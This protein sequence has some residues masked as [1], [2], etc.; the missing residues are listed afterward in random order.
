MPRILPDIIT[1]KQHQDQISQ[2]PDVYRPER[3]PH[4]GK[5]GLHCHGSYERNVPR[6]EGLALVMGSLCIPRFY[7]PGCG[8]TCSRLPACISLQRHYSWKSQ[9]AV[10]TLLLA[11][12]SI[13][14]ISRQLLPSRHTIG[15]WWRRLQAQYGQHSFHLRNRFPDLGRHLLLPDFWSACLQKM[16]LADAMAWLDR[17]GV[18]VP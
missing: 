15:R 12:V 11:G 4:C 18:I 13:F 8:S 5:A 7:C 1:I 14:K 16:S 17:D 2:N 10:L 6:G 9:Q 3:C